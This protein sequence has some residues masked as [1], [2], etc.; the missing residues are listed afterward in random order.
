VR[1]A[2]L[3]R[4]RPLLTALTTACSLLSAAYKGAQNNILKGVEIL[5]D[6]FDSVSSAFLLTKTYWL[7]NWKQIEN[8]SCM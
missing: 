5:Q 8:N 1:E 7:L 3:T 6:L 2:L 4:Q